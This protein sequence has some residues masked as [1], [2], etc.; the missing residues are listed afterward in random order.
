LRHHCKRLII[1]DLSP[2]CIETCAR[3]FRD[4]AH[5]EYCV[6]DGMS[7][8]VTGDQS[9]DFVFSF[10]SLVHAEMDVIVAYLREIKRILRPAG[11][12]VIHHSNLGQ[13]RAPHGGP[14]TAATWNH[15]RSG[16]V[17]ADAFRQALGFRPF[18]QP[19]PPSRTRRTAHASSSSR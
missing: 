2:R 10:D 3:R 13:Y 17:S 18:E 1:V 15:W 14:L 4:S 19:T 12:A 9:V 8:A 5:I 6:N 16:T 7:L 11:A